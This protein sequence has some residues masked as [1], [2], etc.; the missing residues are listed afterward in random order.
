MSG[1]GLGTL[2][3]WETLA[4]L[5]ASIT[6]IGGAGYGVLGWIR[7]RGRPSRR[8]VSGSGPVPATFVGAKGVCAISIARQFPTGYRLEVQNLSPQDLFSPGVK[9]TQNV[10]STG[11]DSYGKRRRVERTYWELAEVLVPGARVSIPVWLPSGVPREGVIRVQWLTAAYSK[12]DRYP[13]S[14][15]G[16]NVSVTWS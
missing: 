10:R 4:S 2:S 9:F 1:W 14:A 8:P 3:A 15:D 5:L 7:G 12:W 13:P 16:D 11:V 6:V